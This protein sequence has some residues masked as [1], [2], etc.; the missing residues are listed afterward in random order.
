MTSPRAE[1][2]CWLS[3]KWLSS[4]T[5]RDPALT[6][7]VRSCTRCA[8]KGFVCAEGPRVACWSCYKAHATCSFGDSKGKKR[9]VVIDL[10]GPVTPRAR[11]P[12][13]G[14]SHPP[15]VNFDG[16]AQ[17]VREVVDGSVG[18]VVEVA[19]RTAKGDVTAVQDQVDRTDDALTQVEGRM[20]ALE[21][22]IATGLQEREEDR[23]R[24]RAAEV[25]AAAARREAETARSETKALRREH[26]RRLAT[27][28][29]GVKRAARLAED[30]EG[31]VKGETPGSGD[32]PGQKGRLRRIVD[33]VDS[34]KGAV[35]IILDELLPERPELPEEDKHPLGWEDLPRIP[36]PDDSDEDAEGETDESEE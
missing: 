19:I 11:N 28:E 25:A 21:A 1:E 33:R 36:G 24:I 3:R 7:P 29:K 15:A 23:A 12:A 10:E 31:M 16:I 22:L 13:A 20:A 2:L 34:L 4:P 17:L 27:I 32:Q 26:R 35:D 9:A 6:I 5:P 8:E 14:P 30:V 18:A